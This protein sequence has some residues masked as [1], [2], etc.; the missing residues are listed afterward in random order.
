M[1]SLNDLRDRS[2]RQARAQALA[3]WVKGRENRGSLEAVGYHA[4]GD[5]LEIRL[6]DAEDSRQLRAQSINVNTAGGFGVPVG[7]E[8]NLEIALQFF[9]CFRPLATV[10][11][12]DRGGETRHPMVDDVAQLGVLVAENTQPGSN[13]VTSFGSV[14]FF[15]AKFSSQYILLPYELWEDSGIDIDTWWGKIIGQRIAR[16]QSKT[17][18]SKL[19]AQATKGATAASQTAIA[20]DDLLNLEYSLDYSYLESPN[21]A[22]MMHP[23]IRKTVAELKTTTGA[24]IFKP[25][26]SKAELDTIDGFPC[27]WNRWMSS[28]IASGTQSVL[29]GDFSRVHIRDVNTIRIKKLVERYADSD[30][31]GLCGLLRSDANLMDAGTHPLQY[32]VH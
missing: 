30:Q 10:D 21:C 28:T 17:W 4:A 32:L 26:R 6:L 25:R 11:R 12:L 15:P 27:I 3:S 14:S 1:L 29:F 24:Y 18:T 19:L 7:F 5:E 13:D 8:A 9:D 16:I 2:K 31:I 22:F 23:T 20:A